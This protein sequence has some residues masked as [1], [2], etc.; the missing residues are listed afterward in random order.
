MG[1]FRRVDDGTEFIGC[2]D[3]TISKDPFI[4]SIIDVNKS[5]LDFYKVFMEK[6]E[7]VDDFELSS[8]DSVDKAH[9]KVIDYLIELHRKN[10]V[11][12]KREIPE[13]YKPYEFTCKMEPNNA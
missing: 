7:T 13:E 11:F 12:P 1:I 6:Y 5:F 9:N 4:Q 2:G 8:I 3:L 10:N